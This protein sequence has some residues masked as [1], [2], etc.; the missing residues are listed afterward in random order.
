[1]KFPATL[2]ELQAAKYFYTGTAKL[3]SCGKQFLW[4]ITPAG[5][6]MPFTAHEDSRLVPHHTVCEN[7]KQFR[8]A[9]R[10]HA[11]RVEPKRAK[12]LGLFGE[13]KSK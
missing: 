1:V 13:A 8:D 9:N 11:D 6:W 5:K 7:V 10:T 2:E 3:C 4:F 12:Q